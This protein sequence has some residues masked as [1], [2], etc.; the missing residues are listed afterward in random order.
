MNASRPASDRFGPGMA[1]AEYD[2]LYI[3]TNCSLWRHYARECEYRLEI[4]DAMQEEVHAGDGAGCEVLL[5][6][7][8]FAPERAVV[9]VMLL[10][11]VYGFQ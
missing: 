4:F 11:M 10:Y 8:K 9:A 5:L 7:E 1:S 2:T 3:V 6:S